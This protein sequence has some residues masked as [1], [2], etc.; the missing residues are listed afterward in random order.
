MRLDGKHFYEDNR[1]LYTSLIVAVAR[2][3]LSYCDKHEKKKDRCA[4]WKELVEY[5]YGYIKTKGRLRTPRR[6]LGAHPILRSRQTS[7]TKI[8]QGSCAI[9]YRN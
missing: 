5:Y 8:I 3:G 7:N 2:C 9:F 4:A 1:R 6:K